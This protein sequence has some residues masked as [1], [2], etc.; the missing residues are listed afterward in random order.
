M[1]QG[2]GG[3]CPEGTGARSKMLMGYGHMDMEW[4][5]GTETWLACMLDNEYDN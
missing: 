4:N 5:Y 2:V 3:G 1:D